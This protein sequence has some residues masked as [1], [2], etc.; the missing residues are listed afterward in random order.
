MET[1][2]PI[3]L[4][5]EVDLRR[6]SAFP[7]GGAAVP[8]RLSARR[9]AAVPRC[10][11]REAGA[12]RRSGFAAKTREGSLRRSLA[13]VVVVRGGIRGTVRS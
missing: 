8:R 12:R 2:A 9:G 3:C 1:A 7:Q 11:G 13:M 5:R 6:R 4:V 10:F